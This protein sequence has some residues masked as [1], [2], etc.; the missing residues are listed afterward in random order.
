MFFLAF[1]GILMPNEFTMAEEPHV[2]QQGTGLMLVRGGACDLYPNRTLVVGSRHH[3]RICAART[4]N[5]RD[6]QSLGVG[7]GELRLCRNAVPVVC[8]NQPQLRGWKRKAW[9][10][11][12][13]KKGA[14]ALCPTLSLSWA[15]QGVDANGSIDARKGDT[16]GLGQKSGI[17]GRGSLG[18]IHSKADRGH[19][20]LSEVR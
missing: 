20:S 13:C 6:R 1:A 10:E 8:G 11:I 9:Y 7:C 15:T 12:K 3:R 16:L 5:R 14:K 2:T 19:E 4:T 18:Y 17:H